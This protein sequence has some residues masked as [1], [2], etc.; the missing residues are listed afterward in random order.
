MGVAVE[1]GGTEVSVGAEGVDA[2]KVATT[3]GVLGSVGR[4]E[5]QAVEMSIRINSEIIASMGRLLI[6]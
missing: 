5:L 1:V 4:L 2:L 3:P 6:G